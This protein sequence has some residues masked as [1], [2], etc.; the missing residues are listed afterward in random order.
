MKS[1]VMLK[2]NDRTGGR[3][4]ALVNCVLLL[5]QGKEHF[6]AKQELYLG[7]FLLSRRFNMEILNTETTAP[8]A[9]M[10]VYFH[11]FYF[12]AC[13]QHVKQRETKNIGQLLLGLLPMQ[14]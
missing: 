10:S 3:N 4:L 2:C 6:C 11:L 9:E 5:S 13:P 7:D 8:K 12:L 1:V 14:D